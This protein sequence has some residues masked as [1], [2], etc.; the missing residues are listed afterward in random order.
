M[1]NLSHYNIFTVCTG[2][3]LSF[4]VLARQKRLNSDIFRERVAFTYLR[5]MSEPFIKHRIFGDYVFSLTRWGR[6]R[7]A[8]ISC[9][10][11][12]GPPSSRV[13]TETEACF[14]PPFCSLFG[15]RWPGL[16]LANDASRDGVSW[17][18]DAV[19]FDA[20]HACPPCCLLAYMSRD[21]GKRPCM[22]SQ[23]GHNS[24]PVCEFTNRL[25]P[26]QDP[27]I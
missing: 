23:R 14:R 26:R 20:P 27:D 22:E 17:T 15:R 4:S 25:W 5:I 2:T 16:A 24:P 8:Q 6:S 12:E 10:S 21:G 7:L 19:C 13:E 18:I 9:C 11:P 3:S 1:L